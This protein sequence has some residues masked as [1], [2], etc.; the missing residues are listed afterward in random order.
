M[1]RSF[2]VLQYH[3]TCGLQRVKIHTVAG[4]RSEIPVWNPHEALQ[5]SMSI[6]I[7]DYVNIFQD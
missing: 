4:L 7:M 3:Q 6:Q 1:K 2:A 5:L